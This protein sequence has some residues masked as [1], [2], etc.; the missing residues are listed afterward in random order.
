[1][2]AQVT[3]SVK[4]LSRRDLVR[5]GAAAAGLSLG[6]A[7]TAWARTEASTATTV[8]LTVRSRTTRLHQWL[9]AKPRGVAL[10]SHGHGSWPE[11]YQQ[12]AGSLNADGFAVVAPVH[13]DSVHHPERER[14][15]LQQSFPERLADMAAASALGARRFPGLPVIAVGHSFGTLTSLCL[16]GALGGKGSFRDPAVRAVLGFST[17]GRIP[18]LIGADAYAGVATPVMIVT[19]TADLVP[20][21][22]SD[23][24]DHLFP[25]ETI[26]T[27]SYALV[28]RGADH[29]LVAS[30]AFPRAAPPAGLFVRAYGLGDRTALAKLARWRA[31][32]GDRFTVR[33]AQS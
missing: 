12:L 28:V 11:R 21:F 2:G 6:S 31:A 30:D 13:V 10:L 9:P 1:M 32:P 14:F 33:K 26:P 20:G 15:T 16:A 23:P 29:G 25:A 5:A 24:A 18:G 3:V 27:D 17:P 4:A 8:E 19:G 22:V 7:G